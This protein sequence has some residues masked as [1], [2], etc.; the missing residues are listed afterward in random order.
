MPITNRKTM[1]LIKRDV[2]IVSR[3]LTREYAF[4]YKKANG[5]HVWDV[6]GQKYLDFCASVAVMNIGHNNPNVVKAIKKQLKY[7]THCAFS[8]FYAE[9]PVL[10][11]EHLVSMLPKKFDRVFLSNSGTESVEA[12]YKL[13]RWHTNKK[14]VVA[15][16]GAFHGRTMGSLSLTNSKPVH[17]ERFAPFLPVMHAPY[18]HYY[19]M[20]MEPNE[21]SDYCLQ[22]LEKTMKKSDGNLAAVFAEPIQ[23]EGGYIVP[24]KN[25]FKGV[26][27]LCNEYGALLC[28]DEVQAGFFR[29][30]KFIAM[31]NFNVVPDII[32]M[33]KPIGGGLPIGATIANRK[34]MN[35]PPGSHANTFGGNLLACA[36]GMATLDYAKKN[37]LGE[38]AIKIGKRMLER[39]KEMQERYEN[40]GDVRGIGLMIGIEIV[41]SKESRK[42]AKKL[43]NMI[44]DNTLRNG[45]LLLPA[46]ESVIRVCPPLIITKEQADKG[47]DII[48]RA[49]KTMSK[50]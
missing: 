31:E 29:T 20:R 21:C 13:A 3:S 2:D 44:I 23:G 18:P 26:R 30:G 42:P 33:S 40:I 22:E 8:D 36:A 16:K 50:C 37:K 38:N 15:F 27:K 5:C 14:W 19:R 34:I 24:P 7:G 41:E 32:C 17:R 9:M 25:F 47:L 4:A 43:R 39:L 12:A 35:W 28:D 48:E 46:G 1:E 49:I 45:L 6:D 10:F 11:S